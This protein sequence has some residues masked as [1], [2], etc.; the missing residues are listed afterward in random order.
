[1][2]PKQRDKETFWPDVADLFPDMTMQEAFHHGV[3]EMV[4][5]GLM[6]HPPSQEMTAW[7]WKKFRADFMRKGGRSANK[8]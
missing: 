4:R 2:K 3:A 5:M 6:Q 7:E 1:M 8:K